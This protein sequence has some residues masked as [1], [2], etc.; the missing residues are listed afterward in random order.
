MVGMLKVYPF[1]ILE[2]NAALPSVDVISDIHTSLV[3]DY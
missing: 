2:K 3:P 1:G